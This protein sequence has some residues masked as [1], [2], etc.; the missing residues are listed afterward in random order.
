[1]YRTYMYT[2]AYEQYLNCNRLSRSAGVS[3]HKEIET[4]SSRVEV[5]RISVAGI[6]KKTVAMVE[7]A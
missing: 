3:L 2:Q 6:K 1:M 4:P 5:K 7:I